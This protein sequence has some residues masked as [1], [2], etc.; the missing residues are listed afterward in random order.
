MPDF[1]KLSYVFQIFLAKK[2][3]FFFFTQKDELE[4][5]LC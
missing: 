3:F 1:F 4:T 2:F 5:E